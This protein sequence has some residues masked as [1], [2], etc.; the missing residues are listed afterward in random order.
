MSEGCEKDKK[1]LES[2]ERQRHYLSL[3]RWIAATEFMADIAGQILEA[4]SAEC[5]KPLTSLVSFWMEPRLSGKEG[6]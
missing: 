6:N 4:R 2:T 1:G 5:S 3:A